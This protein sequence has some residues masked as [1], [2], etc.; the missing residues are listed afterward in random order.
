MSQ[1][2]VNQKNTELTLKSVFFINLNLK[3][4]QRNV[5]TLG[6]RVPFILAFQKHWVTQDT[7]FNK[8][9][10]KIVLYPYNPHSTQNSSEIIAWLLL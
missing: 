5:I 4:R 10:K 6:I 1:L 8:K 9:K 2:T 7:A 3:K